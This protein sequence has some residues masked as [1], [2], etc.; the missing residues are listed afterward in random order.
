[1]KSNKVQ[2]GRISSDAVLSSTITLKGHIYF[3]S[4]KLKVTHMN[5][6]KYFRYMLYRIKKV[7]TFFLSTIKWSLIM[8]VVII[9]VL[10][11]SAIVYSQNFGEC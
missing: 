3:Y 4:V 6:H 1:M 2:I 9:L 10:P 11:L 5:F 8:M 7:F